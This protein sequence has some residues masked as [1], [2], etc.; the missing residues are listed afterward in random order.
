MQPQEQNPTPQ[1]QYSPQQPQVQTQYQPPANHHQTLETLDSD[2]HLI[3]V[4][5]RHPIGLFLYLFATVIALAAA[6]AL[7]FFLLPNFVNDGN[8]K[9]IYSWVYLA[10]AIVVAVVALFSLVTIFIY[11]QTKMI[12]TN[13]NITLVVQKGLFNRRVSK[14]AMADIEDVNAEQ[15]G[16][17]SMI[18]GFGTLNVETAG[19]VE[20][21]VFTY[22]PHPNY[23]AR[24]ILEAREHA[25]P[26]GE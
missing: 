4:I 13:Q 26:G 18:F 1:P 22:C 21:F 5:H 7:V 25:G 23:Y 8:H 3:T 9:Q 12:L 2:E 6:V 16:I 17:L 20:N 10:F 24:Q 14:L 11:R 15:N 19:E